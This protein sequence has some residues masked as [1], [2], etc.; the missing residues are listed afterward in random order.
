MTLFKAR[1]YAVRTAKRNPAFA[2]K[3]RPSFSSAQPNAGTFYPLTPPPAPPP[4]TPSS[5][6][7]PT[8]N[9]NDASRPSP[10]SR[11]EY[12]NI[13]SASLRRARLTPT[14]ARNRSGEAADDY[15]RPTQ[16]ALPTPNRIPGLKA[17]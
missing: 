16:K 12:V 17:A 2:W 11:W 5:S 3:P 7:A 4:T 8:P 15:T 10:S 1:S 13:D 9:N 14:H 6:R